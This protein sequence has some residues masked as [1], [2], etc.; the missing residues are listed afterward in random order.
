MAFSK[1]FG[2]LIQDCF[3]YTYIYKKLV[4]KKR[5]IFGIIKEVMFV[6]QVLKLVRK[7]K[8]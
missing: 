8:I 5:N 2:K 1:C 7:C 4:Q 6:L 3:I